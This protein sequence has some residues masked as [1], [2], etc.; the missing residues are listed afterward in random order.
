MNKRI[1]KDINYL[2][3]IYEEKTAKKADEELWEKIVQKIKEGDYGGKAGQWNARKA[4]LAVKEYKKQGGKY[5]GKKSKKNSLKVWTDENWKYDESKSRY[6]PEKVWEKLTPEEKEL[7][8]KTKEEAS[9]N[10]KQF[11]KYPKEVKD[12]IM[13]ILKK[14]RK[15]GVK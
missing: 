5:I 4:Q 3:L 2:I 13:K 14:N 11:A 6:L 1:T 12:K 7:L 15:H 10:G 9:L 8:N